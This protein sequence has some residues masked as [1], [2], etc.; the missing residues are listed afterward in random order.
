VAKSITRKVRLRPNRA[1]PITAIPL[2]PAAPSR[3]ARK[4][5]AR[6]RP[7]DPEFWTVI[8][9]L[10]EPIPVSRAELDAIESYFADLLDAVFDQSRN[11]WP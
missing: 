5:A 6:L 7:S 9:E 3:P 1:A 4:T 11:S 8:N 2:P 10:S